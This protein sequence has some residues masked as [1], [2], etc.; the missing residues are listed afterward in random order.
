VTRT[1]N[2][3][4]GQLQY[5]LPPN[6]LANRLVRPLPAE[7]VARSTGVP[8]RYLDA[9]SEE[10]LA[11]LEQVK[12]PQPPDGPFSK[13]PLEF[14]G[15]WRLLDPRPE[16]VLLDAAGGVYTY[17]DLV[18]V[19]ERYLH[20]LSIAPALRQR[21]EPLVTCLESDAAHIP[22]PDASV[23][24]ISC[25]HSFEHF[26]GDSDIRFIGE[27]Q[28][29]L[30]PGGR[31]CILP[32]FIA[33]RYY[34]MTTDFTLAKRYDRLARRLIDPTAQLPGGN[35]YARVYDAAALR[36]R[37]LDSIEGSAFDAEIVQLRIDGKAVPDRTL[38]R[39]RKY[40]AIN[41]PFRALLITR[42][43]G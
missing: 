21:L 2:F 24:K 18:N 10:Y 13:K 20:D 40:T 28:R 30:R 12:P 43:A 35:G 7:D 26:E 27:I 34:E 5:H 31:A 37:V 14:Y 38:P 1:G 6:F 42:H 36:R 3:T 29:L 32:I 9:T 19:R 22:L 39:N 16:D 25:H 4:R 15:T 33:G 8:F 11:W 41:C 17:V 23:D